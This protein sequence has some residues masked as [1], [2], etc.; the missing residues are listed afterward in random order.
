MARRLGFW[1]VILV[2][3]AGA[4]FSEDLPA[5][6]TTLLAASVPAQARIEVDAAGQIVSI[7][8]VADGNGAQPSIL[9]VY[10]NGVKIAVTP[11]IIQELESI[12]STID[13]RNGGGV[14]QKKEDA[15]LADAIEPGGLLW[16]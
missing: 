6:R 16:A 14:Y 5:A 8:N 4:A 11:Q 12:R 9:N 3:M 7:F 10:Q 2:A 15:D 1:I 13:W